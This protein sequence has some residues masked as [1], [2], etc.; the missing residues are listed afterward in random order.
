MDVEH[1]DGKVQSE[2]VLAVVYDTQSVVLERHIQRTGEVG[3]KVV[4][5]V[6]VTVGGGNV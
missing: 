2:H 3:V 6:E 4:S 1:L 5:G